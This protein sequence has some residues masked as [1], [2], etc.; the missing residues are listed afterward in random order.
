MGLYVEVDYLAEF[1]AKFE[2]VFYEARG[3]DGV[4]VEN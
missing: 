4:F 1:K 3:P 2:M